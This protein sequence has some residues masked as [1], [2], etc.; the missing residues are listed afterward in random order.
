MNNANQKV[1]VVV[2][3]YNRLELLKECLTS[4]RNQSRKPDVVI[5]VNNASTDGTGAW[6]AMQDDLVILERS[7]NEG[8][9]GGFHYGMKYAF[10]QHYDWVWVMDDDAAPHTDCLEKM[11]NAHKGQDG[12]TVLA[13]VV[14]E[15]NTLITN[16]RSNFYVRPDLSGFQ[17]PLKA[18][19]ELEPQVIEFASFVG[20]MISKDLMEKC[21]LPD[22]D[23]FFQNDDVE[24]CLRINKYGK[25]LLVPS[26]IIEH[27]FVKKDVEVK[28]KNIGGIKTNDFTLTLLFVKFFVQR[29]KILIKE[30]YFKENLSFK[31][32][33]FRINVLLNYLKNFFKILFFVPFKYKRIYFNVYI[34]AYVQGLTGKF[35]NTNVMKMINDAR[36]KEMLEAA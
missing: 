11:L 24:Y 20:F 9:A 10:E 14:K 32:L 6:L 2:V 15:G 30:K 5:V 8:S 18:G 25:I 26:A 31:F 35:N 1:A 36:T 21:G 12:L 4:L 7:V 19:K 34:E 13:P 27:K 29:N 28:S 17:Q 22:K 23:L 16:H 33:L 3:T